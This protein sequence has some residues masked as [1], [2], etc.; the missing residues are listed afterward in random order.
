MVK[1]KTHKN[2]RTRRKIKR[3]GQQNI[4]I[5]YNTFNVNSKTITTI[6][7]TS[8]EPNITL[9]PLP[10]ST[11]VMYDPDASVPEWLHYLVINIHNGDI[12]SGTIIQP[13]EGPSPSPGSG[14]HHYIFEQLQQQTQIN[15]SIHSQSGFKIDAFHKKYNLEMRA[16]KQFIVN[17]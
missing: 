14:T 8:K 16:T 15:V 3:G 13:Y 12:S 11:L 17:A 6:A 10:L 5:R 1:G 7:A 2:I 9:L 4:K